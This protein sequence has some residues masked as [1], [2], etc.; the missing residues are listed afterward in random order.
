M[1]TSRKDLLS[2]ASK[3]CVRLT[4]GHF[5]ELFHYK[6][7][8]YVSH[9][10]ASVSK[11]SEKDALLM[12]LHPAAKDLTHSPSDYFSTIQ[13]RSNEYSDKRNDIV[14]ETKDNIIFRFS[15][16]FDLNPKVTVLQPN[17]KLSKLVCQN[18][19]STQKDI[20]FFNGSFFEYAKDKFHPINH[21]K[22]L[23]HFLNMR[24]D[25]LYFKPEEFFSVKSI[26]EE[27][28][29]NQVIEKTYLSDEG[30]SFKLLVPQGKEVASIKEVKKPKTQQ[31]KGIKY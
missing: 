30:L 31:K 25:K 28:K 18:N 4:D 16:T 10:L 22:A 12:F 8:F 23:D 3:I 27:A 11:I 1:A 2:D 5:Y 24:S 13:Q 19:E 15:D 20:Y 21:D 29:T 9:D 17:L 6:E 14:F 26:Q 7:A